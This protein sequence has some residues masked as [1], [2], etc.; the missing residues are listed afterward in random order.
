MTWPK[1]FDLDLWDYSA[2][3]RCNGAE[4]TGRGTS[5]NQALA[6][7]AALGEAVERATCHSMNIRTTGVA[8]HPDFN[9]AKNSAMLELIERKSY[10]AALIDN[11]LF[12]DA[13]PYVIPNKTQIF[14]AEHGVLISFFNIPTLKE[15]VSVVM[16]AAEG[17]SSS[18]PFGGIIGVAASA[19]QAIASNKAFIECFRSLTAWLFG[20]ETMSAI[21]YA[22]FEK[23]E[24]KLPKFHK[25]LAL[26]IDYWRKARAGLKHEVANN[27]ALDE[28]CFRR[29]PLPLE[30]QPCPIF[31]VKCETAHSADLYDKIP[32][33]I[34]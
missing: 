21:S 14:L 9:I 4:F 32:L 13:F 34:G 25:S 22:E 23:I 1:R 12:N 30:L 17:V 24:N 3:F 33:L 8:V 10:Q 5:T 2:S 29:L 15:G 28:M 18:R 7:N 20:S 16:C 27:V 31:A 11:V 6:L 26:N 19:D